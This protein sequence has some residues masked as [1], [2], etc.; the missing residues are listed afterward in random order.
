VIYTTN[1]IG[2]LNGSLRKLLHYQGHFPTEEAVFKL[3]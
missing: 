2:S 1:A 3:L